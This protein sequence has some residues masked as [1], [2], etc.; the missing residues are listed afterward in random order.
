MYGKNDSAV[1]DYTRAIRINPELPA[2][3]PGEKANDKMVKW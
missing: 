3:P 2:S 1:N